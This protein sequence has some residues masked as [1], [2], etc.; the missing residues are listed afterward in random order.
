MKIM[1]PFK[2][3]AVYPQAFSFRIAVGRKSM[4]QPANP[5][6]LGKYHKSS[7]RSRASNT[8]WGFKHYVL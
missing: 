1:W 5:S 2:T 8:S 3:R 4:G 7:N 6:S